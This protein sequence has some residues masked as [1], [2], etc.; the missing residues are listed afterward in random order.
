MLSGL[1]KGLG[2]DPQCRAKGI[3]LAVPVRTTSSA[4]QETSPARFLAV[5]VYTPLSGSAAPS[6]TREHSLSS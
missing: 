5:Q 4:L 1:S 6:T 3:W 2:A